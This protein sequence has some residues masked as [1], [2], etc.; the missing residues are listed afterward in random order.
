MKGKGFD[1][2]AADLAIAVVTVVIALTVMAVSYVPESQG[3][4]DTA[5][6]AITAFSFAPVL[7]DTT[8]GSQAVL[9]SATITDNLSGL[10]G[11]TIFFSAVGSGQT[12]SCSLGEPERTSGT[13]TDG[14]YVGTMTL[15]QYSK[16]GEWKVNGAGLYDRTRN[17]TI[18]ARG[19]AAFGSYSTLRTQ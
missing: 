5:G 11:A 4:E 7:A 9:V 8:S 19:A 17:A 10:D 1:F 15:P 2:D 13:A 12:A 3:T 14:T 6:P 16:V 18:Y